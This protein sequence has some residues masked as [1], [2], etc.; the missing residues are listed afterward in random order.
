[1]GRALE[2]ARAAGARGEVPIGALAVLG[3]E[4]VGG[5]GNQVEQEREATA[6]A[7]LLAI[8]QAAQAIGSW[9]LQGVT[10]YTTLEPCPM[11]AGAL[12]LARVERVV[13][14]ADDPK[15]GAVR[16]VYDVLESPAGNHH[17]QVT[18]GCRAEESRQLLQGFF[19]GLRAPTA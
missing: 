14:G 17:P 11:C 7:E 10:L 6:H 19:Q 15:K 5:A 12:L 13:Y 8:R 2:L 18:G 3:Q 4:V 1:M 9:R 16:T